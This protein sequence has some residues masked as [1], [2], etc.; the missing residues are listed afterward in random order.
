MILL[1]A[2]S[3]MVLSVKRKFGIFGTR[4]NISSVTRQP[5]IGL[6]ALKKCTNQTITFVLFVTYFD[7]TE[8]F[9]RTVY[10]ACD[11][12]RTPRHKPTLNHGVFRS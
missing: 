10:S 7:V 9:Q 2:Q 1:F 5:E 4:C 8:H 3:L 12:T 6:N 11:R